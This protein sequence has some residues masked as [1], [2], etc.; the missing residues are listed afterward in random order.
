MDIKLAWLAGILEGEGSLA[1]N[2]AGNKRKHFVFSISITNTDLMILN[3][4]VSILKNIG[5][6]T[7]LHKR[8]VY[9]ENRK[10]GYNLNINGIDNLIKMINAIMPYL[11][12][13]KKSQANL[14]LEFLIRRKTIMD[15]NIGN[16]ARRIAYDEVDYSYLKAFQD[17]KSITESV[18]TA[19]FLSLRDKDTVRTATI[20]KIADSSRNDLSLNSN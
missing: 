9:F 20:I 10:I 4:C 1:L 18:E 3:E 16:S 7:H 6:E 5:V 12:G 11:I 14:M 15:N 19:R 17:L 8:K 2:K 13:Q